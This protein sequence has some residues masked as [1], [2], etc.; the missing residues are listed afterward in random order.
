ML[1]SFAVCQ[2]ISHLAVF[3]LCDVTTR[4][5][6][7]CYHTI[8]WLSI[9]TPGGIPRL[10]LPKGG[11]RTGQAILLGRSLL[12][13]TFPKTILSDVILSIYR[14]L[15]SQHPK[16]LLLSF[17]YMICRWSRSGFSL[18]CLQLS[19]LCLPWSA[20]WRQ[21]PPISKFRP[22]WLCSPRMILSLFVG[23]LVVVLPA[24]YSW[25]LLAAQ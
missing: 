15:S 7:F 10:R 25:S 13:A 22:T 21:C 23:I 2:R 9:L 24:V 18:T 8:L 20:V 6:L 3:V 14:I 16:G 17:C 5:E 11:G 4:T 12:L 1:K 19:R